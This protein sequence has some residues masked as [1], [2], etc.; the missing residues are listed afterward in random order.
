[1]PGSH[2]QGKIDIAALQ[3]AEKVG[4]DGIDVGVRLV[5]AGSADERHF[6]GWRDR[7]RAEVSVSATNP[8]L[9]TT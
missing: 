9:G 5:P 7:L 6:V 2:K 4:E 3:A 8:S 1:M